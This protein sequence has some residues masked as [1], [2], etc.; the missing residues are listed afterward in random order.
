MTIEPEDLQR[1]ASLTLWPSEPDA[2][3]AV[4]PR[5]YPTLQEA[6]HEAG[7]AMSDDGATAWIITASG[8]LLSPAWL[9]GHLG[10]VAPEPAPRR[11]GARVPLPL[12]A[13]PERTLSA[14]APR[15]PRLSPVVALV[16]NRGPESI[17]RS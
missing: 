1:P 17:A 9:R 4:E 8:L 10:E 11:T 16:R 7:L 2:P 3:K 14:R 15:L 5:S 13:L 6:L 12:A